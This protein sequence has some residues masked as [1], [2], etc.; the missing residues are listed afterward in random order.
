MGG[1][2]TLAVSPHPGS[3]FVA[4]GF[5]LLDIGLALFRHFEQHPD[6]FWVVDECREASAL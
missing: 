1:K 3:A 2:R 6:S 4:L 5:K